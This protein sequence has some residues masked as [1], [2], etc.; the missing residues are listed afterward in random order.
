MAVVSTHAAMM[1]SK[2]AISRLPGLMTKRSMPFGAPGSSTSPAKLYTSY[3]GSMSLRALTLARESRLG[4]LGTAAGGGSFPG[5]LE[6]GVLGA[7]RA[8]RMQGRMAV[9]PPRQKVQAVLSALRI[10][11]CTRLQTSSIST[12]G[13]VR[14]KEARPGAL[15]SSRSRPLN[16]HP[17]AVSGDDDAE[18]DE[19]PEP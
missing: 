18:S 12:C 16:C 10:Y 3:F 4:E 14:R 9:A 2:P 13:L 17:T 7:H 1:Q 19:P 15:G 5:G 11:L 8:L 6:S